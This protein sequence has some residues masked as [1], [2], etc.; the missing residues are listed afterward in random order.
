A[1]PTV[2][3]SSTEVAPPE[4]VMVEPP[5]P[6]ETPVITDTAPTSGGRIE[7]FEIGKDGG[8]LV[9]LGGRVRVIFPEGA[10]VE[11]ANV[12]VGGVNGENRIPY[13]RIGR[14]FQITAESQDSQESISQLGAAITIQYDYS[15]IELMNDERDLVLKYYD[16]AA[17]SWRT[18][19][20]QVDTE[21][22]LLSTKTTGLHILGVDIIDWEAAN[23]PTLDAFQVSSFTGAATYNMGFWVPPGP[24][25]LQPNLN[26]SYNSQV[27]DGSTASLSQASWVGMGWSLDTGHIARE[28]NGSANDTSDDTFS[29]VLNGM[30]SPLLKGTDGYYHT[31]DETFWKIEHNTTS[32]TWVIWDKTGTRYY[33]DHQAR[34][35]DLDDHC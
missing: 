34:H 32:D 26:L 15:G 33:F 16:E 5:V 7:E 19:P 20:T 10:L 35:F 12:H 14:P 11:A 1:V 6:A 31:T 21:N 24:G 4:P 17:Q 27:V 28:M 9:A 18:L 23:L 25:G 8:E 2:P 13:L 29:V 30:S 22:N 3:V